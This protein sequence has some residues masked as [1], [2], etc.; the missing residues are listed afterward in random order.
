MVYGVWCMVA[1]YTYGSTL[2]LARY[3]C[4][5][6]WRVVYGSTLYLARYTCD[7]VW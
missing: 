7:G 4:D 6:V 5:G 3:T 1:R 2:Y